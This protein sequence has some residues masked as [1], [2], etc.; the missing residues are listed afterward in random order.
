MRTPTESAALDA[1]KARI[2]YVDPPADLVPSKDLYDDRMGGWDRLLAWFEDNT[3]DEFS[4]ILVFLAEKRGW[5]IPQAYIY[6]DSW[7]KHRTQLD[8]DGN[9]MSFN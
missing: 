9:Y 7:V 1:E 5:T 4:A 6:T 2:A 8:D 3:K